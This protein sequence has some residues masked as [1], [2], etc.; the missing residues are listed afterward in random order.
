MSSQEKIMSAGRAMY[1]LNVSNVEIARTLDV[2]ETTVSNWVTKG[3]WRE[4]RALAAAQKRNVQDRMMK[5]IEYQLEA[6]DQQVD[7][8]R[9]DSSD[10]LPL[11]STGHVDG[12]AKLFAQIKGKELTFATLV[13]VIRE[14]LEHLNQKSPDLAK[15][16]VPHS[17]E[18]LLI[19]KE[20]LAQ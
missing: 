19:K 17:N 18:F 9:V 11:L 10:E 7:K 4:E 20:V 3:G 15:A 12:L 5:L 13:T 2:S 1:M 16:L 14:L 8:N 6:L